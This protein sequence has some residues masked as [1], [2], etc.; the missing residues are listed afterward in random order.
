[1]PG[2]AGVAVFWQRGR[3]GVCDCKV[4]PCR[5]WCIFGAERSL[6]NEVVYRNQLVPAITQ[7][8]LEK[9]RDAR[10][11]LARRYADDATVYPVRAAI[12]DAVEYHYTCSFMV[13]LQ[14]ALKEGTDPTVE[15]KLLRAQQKLEIAQTI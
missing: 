4:E 7:K 14:W 6:A 2:L 13:G 15:A 3:G 9:C 5:C 12:A 10:L 1:M 11:V 8:I